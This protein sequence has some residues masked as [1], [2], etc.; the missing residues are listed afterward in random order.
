MRQWTPE[1]LDA[2]EKEAHER[3]LIDANES[4]RRE[5]TLAERLEKENA[6]QA[7][8]IAALEAALRRWG[9]HMHDC[10]SIDGV[11]DCTCGLVDAR[12]LLAS[13]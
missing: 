8:R 11:T 9:E 4:L 1:E 12:A 13:D 10:D 6:A 2:L 3:S 5:P 7:A